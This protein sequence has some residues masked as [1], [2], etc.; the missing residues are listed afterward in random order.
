[1]TF[2]KT[3][4]HILLW[5]T[6]LIC[7]IAACC[8]AAE[9]DAVPDFGFEEFNPAKYTGETGKIVLPVQGKDGM[10]FLSKILNGQPGGTLSLEGKGSEL[11]APVGK[12]TLDDYMV[13]IPGRGD[14]KW[15]ISRESKP[16]EA[17][18]IEVK[19]GESTF[20]DAQTGIKQVIDS[21]QVGYIRL[22]CKAQASVVLEYMDGDKVFMTSLTVSGTSSELAVPAGRF[23]ISYYYFSVSGEKEPSWQIT[24]RFFG[25]T[26]SRVIDVQPD[27]KTDLV[28]NA[29]TLA[30]L[31][32]KETGVVKLP[33]KGRT[34]VQLR[35]AGS[36]KNGESVSL[37]SNNGRL[38]IPAGDYENLSYTSEVRGK[39]K[40]H[41][42]VRW[43]MKPG[44]IL[45]V[46]PGHKYRVGARPPLTASVSAEKDKNRVTFTLNT[47]DAD[48]SR[49][50]L[51]SFQNDPGF[52]VLLK[53]GKLLMSGKLE[54]G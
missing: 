13:T 6:A 41:W 33:L 25:D 34:R 32:T 50:S 23:K 21:G 52:K 44:K 37:F 16:G 7:G 3:V 48:G 43:Q 11:I 17:P 40:S 5:M 51:I 8:S 47:A 2:S 49:V 10:A 14:C 35:P 1:M 22:P 24:G 42:I 20:V 31:K 38:S 27:S 54:Y 53:S 4:K 28:T 15:T 39:D 46:R 26:D 9:V 29:R 45:R 12:Y 18:E 30:F 19:A 36:G